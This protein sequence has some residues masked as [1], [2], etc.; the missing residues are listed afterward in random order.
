MRDRAPVETDLG[1]LTDVRGFSCPPP[2]PGLGETTDALW[3]PSGLCTPSPR[4]VSWSKCSEKLPD[5]TQNFLS[6]FVI[7]DDSFFFGL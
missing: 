5:R 2:P 4:G 3:S 6:L 1:T 7:F